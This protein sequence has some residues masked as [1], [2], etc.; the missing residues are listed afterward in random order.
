MAKKKAFPKEV[1]SA[2]P[3]GEAGGAGAAEIEATL[4][5]PLADE[6]GGEPA[7]SSGSKVDASNVEAASPVASVPAAPQPGIL[8]D[9]ATTRTAASIPAPTLLQPLARRVAPKVE[10]MMQL[11]VFRL[12]L[13][14]YAV[15]I[16]QV[17]E[18]TVT[19]EIARMPRTPAFLRGVANI[20]GE[21]IAVLDL[22]ERFQLTPAP[23]A[24]PAD[25]RT[26]TLVVEAAD[27]SIG[28][29]VRQMPQ[30]TTVPAALL[31]QA[32]DFFRTL[33]IN[34]KY[35]EGLVRLSDQD[36]VI[37]LLDLLRLLQPAEILQLSP[38]NAVIA[39]EGGLPMPAQAEMPLPGGAVVR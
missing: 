36:R 1:A 25:R 5:S 14:E 20:R 4:A 31:E 8:D 33:S 21:L 27:Y 18:I 30:A 11:I 9:D 24:D 35:I 34:D 12:G 26:Y 17:K 32:P 16:A 37:I 28:I 29:L 15:R 13:E 23:L 6:A 2:T 19:P 10:Q 22:E 39:P 7:A 38:P 3:P